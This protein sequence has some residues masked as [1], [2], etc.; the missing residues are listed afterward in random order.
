MKFQPTKITRPRKMSSLKKNIRKRLK[1]LKEYER[2]ADILEIGRRVFAQNS[3]DGV[4]TIMGII[5]GSYFAQV[6]DPKIVVGA[7]IGACIAMGVS[8]VWATY[9]TEQAERRKKMLELEKHTLRRL[10]NTKIEKAEI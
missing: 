5:I 4:L 10:H 8:G 1:E 9:Y 3:F 2:I 6:T 7:G